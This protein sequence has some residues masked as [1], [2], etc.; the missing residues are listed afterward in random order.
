MAELIVDTSVWIDYFRGRLSTIVGGHLLHHL[1]QG[2]V[3]ITDVILNEILTGTKS[4]KEYDE[5]ADVFWA[6]QQFR[7][8]PAQTDDFNHC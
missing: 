2:Q 6:I 1:S 4:T 3:A 8:E 5:V 7:I